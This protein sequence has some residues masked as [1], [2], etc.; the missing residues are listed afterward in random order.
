MGKFKAGGKAAFESVKANAA[1]FAAA[2]GS[3]I[4]TF[5]IKGIN[6]FQNLAIA[7]S[8]FADATGL[9]VEEASRL[10][11]VTGDLGIEAGSVE[12][13]IGKMNQNLG[14]SPDLFKELGVQV[15]Y[16]NDG[17]VNANET[18]LNVVDRLNKIKDPAERARVASQLLGKGWRDMAELIAGGSDKLRASLAAVSSAKTITPAEAEKAKKFRDTMNDL[19]DVVEDLA[20]VV[21]EKLVP[22][23]ADAGNELKDAK[24]SI[25]VAA[26]SFDVLGKKMTGTPTEQFTANMNLA[27]SALELFGIEVGKKDT[28]DNLVNLGGYAEAAADNLDKMNQQTL[29][30]IKYGRLQP[31]QPLTTA[32]NSLATELKN[33]DQAWANLT[34]RLDAQVAFDNAKQTLVEL[35]AAAA[36]AFDTGADSDIVKYNALAANFAGLLS[37]I[38]EGLG[39]IASREIKIK[40]QAEGPAAAL[41]LADYY[42]RGGELAGLSQRDLLTMSGI[43]GRAMGGPV[44]AGG[45]YLVGERGPELLTMGANSGYVTPN[46]GM[47][48]TINVTVTSADPNQVVAAIQQWTR[49]NGAIPVAT[50][51]NVRR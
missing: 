18:F 37:N 11:E 47:G 15:A 17:T 45:T 21:G 1:T 5:A 26:A 34:G 22:M 50:T 7:A 28:Q 49:N 6:D 43:P 8:K 44:S 51:T 3:A 13:A 27:K 16:A 42:R 33:I 35:E 14:K 2:A 40:F 46:A 23:L 32:A 19:K 10:I 30:A 39:N 12:T 41:A 31:L 36:K 48:N 25:D 38:A 20:L 24:P 29:N 4:A 9:S